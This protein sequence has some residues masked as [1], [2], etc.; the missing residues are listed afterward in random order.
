MLAKIRVLLLPILLCKVTYDIF[1]WVFMFIKQISFK[2]VNKCL[3]NFKNYLSRIIFFE[4]GSFGI[5]RL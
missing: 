4:L 3:S 2:N 1:S 5:F